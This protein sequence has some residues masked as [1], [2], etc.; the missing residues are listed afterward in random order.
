MKNVNEQL[1]KLKTS[2]QQ[3]NLVHRPRFFRLT[4]NTDKEEFDL[5]LKDSDLLLTDEIESQIGELIKINNPGKKFSTNDLLSETKK[6]L[7]G[8]SIDAYGVWI[9]YPWSRRLVHSLDEKEFIE[10]RTSRNKYK[11]TEEEQNILSKK[12]VGVIGLSVGQSVSLTMAMERGCGELRLADFDTLELTNLNRI[13]TGIHNLGL[14]KVY[15]VAREIAEIDPFIKTVCFEKGL[16]EANMDEFFMGNGKLD[17]LIEESDGF[18]IKIL[19]RYKARELKIPVIMEG[20]D[21]CAVDVERFDLEPSRSILHGLV[22]HLDMSKLKDL[23]T[24]EQKI[25]YMLDILGIETASLKLKA[26]MLEIDQSINTWP[27]LASSVTMGGGITADVSRRILLNT[28]TDSGR[29][30][31]DIEELIG[32]K[33]KDVKPRNKETVY[34]F[35]DFKTLSQTVKSTSYLDTAHLSKELAE[36]LVIA[37]SQA[38]SAGNNQPWRW[39]YINNSL[40]LFNGFDAGVTML[41]FDNLS[42]YV[43]I[44]AAIEN[45]VIASAQNGYHCEFTLFPDDKI[46]DLVVSF[47]FIKND[48]LKNKNTRVEAL[49]LRLTNRML[50]DR[51]PIELNI[52]K[53]LKSAACEVAGVTL[54]F[55][56]TEEELNAVAD[57]LGEIDK[58]RLLEKIGHKD[59][60]EEIRWTQEENDQKRDGVDLRT[61]DITNTELAGLQMSKDGRVMDLVN[62]WKGGGAF[63]KLTKKSIDAAGAVGIIL[64]NGNQHKDYINGGLA[65]EK[66]WLEATL[67]GVA[68]QP[69]SASVFMFARAKKGSDAYMSEKGV[70]QLK[71][72][73]L[74]FE[75]TFAIDKGLTD[76][77]IF[78]L[79]LTK[80]PPVK[81]LRKPIEEIFSY[82]N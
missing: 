44:G 57:V 63:K 12:I 29:Y 56:T 60:I 11:I 25:P 76:I 34:A 68:F 55:F 45:V 40:L 17:L 49:G 1:E 9:Y 24:T 18:D 80:E 67:N 2:Q 73:R 6:F 14:P 58:I 35:T 36:K 78:R 77:F 81:S 13:R 7:N 19:S 79:S 16:F 51:C 70:T 47:H 82:F 52:L 41:G 39:S 74:Q 43:A 38:P 23:Q 31:V 42:S 8:C 30:H 15:A 4:N 20:S 75:E 28:Y 32:N 21:R 64:I 26:S 10:V 33:K 46:K 71:N 61:L 62:E 3:A 66:V 65:V 72:L 69:M 59:F 22:D 5:L 53:K 27:Q 37:G 54:K 48:E 50:G